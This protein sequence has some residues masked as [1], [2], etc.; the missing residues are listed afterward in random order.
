MIKHSTTVTFDS[1][2]VFLRIGWSLSLAWATFACA[3]GHGGPVN[4]LLSWGMFLSLGRMT[5]MVYLLHPDVITVFFAQFTYTFVYTPMSM[6]NYYVGLTLILFG[7]AFVTGLAV[8]A[9]F[10]NLEKLLM[11]KLLGRGRKEEVKNDVEDKTI[12]EEDK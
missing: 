12:V 6:A 10:V 2:H 8:E 7:L 1:N 9:P 4:A 3:K 11:T 5:Y